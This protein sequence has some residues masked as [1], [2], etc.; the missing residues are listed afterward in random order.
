MLLAMTLVRCRDLADRMVD[1]FGTMFVPMPTGVSQMGNWQEFYPPWP[2]PQRGLRQLCTHCFVCV[3]KY[4][5]TAVTPSIVTFLIN[6]V[7][8]CV[9]HIRHISGI[10]C[11]WVR[12]G[13]IGV[14]KIRIDHIRVA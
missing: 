12:A 13:Q 7:E 2:V 6:A 14:A 8:V 9:K 3:D 4:P 5:S 11:A 1:R 10:G